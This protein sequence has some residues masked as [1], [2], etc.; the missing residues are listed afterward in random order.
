MDRG[1]AVGLHQEGISARETARRLGVSDSVI[2]RLLERFQDTGSTDERHRSGRSRCTTR[3]QD[4]MP[5]A[6]D[7]VTAEDSQRL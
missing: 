7:G 2:R 3:R 1:Q 4:L 6:S 5:H